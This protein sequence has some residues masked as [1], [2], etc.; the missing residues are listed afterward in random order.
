MTVNA[1]MWIPPLGMIE[2]HARYELGNVPK[3]IPCNQVHDARVAHGVQ[4]QVCDG[5]NDIVVEVKAYTLELVLYT[6]KEIMTDRNLVG[7]P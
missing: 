5:W 2:S 7:A 3:L 4:V 6:I 1:G